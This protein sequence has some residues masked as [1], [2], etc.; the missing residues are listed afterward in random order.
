MPDP[1]TPEA[2]KRLA[3]AMEDRREELGLR[4]QDVAA[5][6]GVSLKTLHSARTG[7]SGIAPLTR[8]GIEVGLQWE[9]KTVLRILEEDAPSEQ[10]ADGN[11]LLR[12]RD[13]G[14]LSPRER[15][16]AIEA[17]T[18]AVWRIR[19]SGERSA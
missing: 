1:I 12:L 16:V 2:R 9:R 15:D 7:D 3:E 10:R 17:A 18:E 19:Q 11:D 8:H 13:V 5:A 4:W 14:P 6:G